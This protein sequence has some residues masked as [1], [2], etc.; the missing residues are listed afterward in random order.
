MILIGEGSHSLLTMKWEEVLVILD[1]QNAD[2]GHLFPYEMKES[3]L[4]VLLVSG[5][6]ES[7]NSV[8]WYSLF[9]HWLI[10]VQLRWALT[11]SSSLRP[12]SYSNRPLLRVDLCQSSDIFDRL[13]LKRSILLAIEKMIASIGAVSSIRLWI[14]HRVIELSVSSTGT[15]TCLWFQFWMIY[16]ESVSDVRDYQTS[17]VINLSKVSWWEGIWIAGESWIRIPWRVSLSLLLWQSHVGYSIVLHGMVVKASTD[18]T[19]DAR[20]K[21]NKPIPEWETHTQNQAFETSTTRQFNS[22]QSRQRSWENDREDSGI[23]F[24]RS[25]TENMIVRSWAKKRSRTKSQEK[26]Q[27]NVSD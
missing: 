12:K 2:D 3:S 16:N 8:Q 17:W 7:C 13:G 14:S 6:I 25:H 4:I 18:D 22:A 9:L 20:C 10:K 26:Y 19:Q 21:R 15:D 23:E 11:R 24:R 1:W 27:V 5:R